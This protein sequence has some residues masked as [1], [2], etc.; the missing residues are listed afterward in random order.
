MKKTI[1]ILFIGISIL[2]KGQNI[3]PNYSFENY[4]TCPTAGGQIAFAF[5]WYGVTASTSTDYYNSCGLTTSNQLPK[6]GNGFA[7]IWGF[8]A[9]SNYREYLQVQL[10]D[11]LLV[12]SCY[13]IDYYVNLANTCKYAV[14]VDAYI[15][16]WS[17]SSTGQGM[18]LR[19][20]LR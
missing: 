3:V 5:P 2:G 18:Y 8:S 15:S 16:N 19:Y 10:S 4:T 6:T 17:I 14:S 13:L 9:G 1:F 12:G 11:S 7:G 20:H